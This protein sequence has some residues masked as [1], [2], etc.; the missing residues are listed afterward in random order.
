MKC[1][2][3]VLVVLVL[4][5]VGEAKGGFVHTFTTNASVTIGNDATP[6]IHNPNTWYPE[7]RNPPTMNAFYSLDPPSYGGNGGLEHRG[8]I[9]FDISTLSGINLTSATLQLFTDTVGGNTTLSGFYGD[10]TIALTDWYNIGNVITYLPTSGYP[11]DSIDVTQFLQSAINA[12]QA[13]VGFVIWQSPSQANGGN[14]FDGGDLVLAANTD[15]TVPLPLEPPIPPIGPPGGG[16]PPA[17]PEPS[18]L[19]LLG[20]GATALLGYS[21]RRR[22]LPAGGVNRLT[23]HAG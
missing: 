7:G 6:G 22:K 20:L 19:T 9:E 16:G 17:V 10:G 4:G 15:F 8:I 11:F 2:T 3:L 14:T 21:W 5:G 18:T 12:D 1:A 23:A 13:D